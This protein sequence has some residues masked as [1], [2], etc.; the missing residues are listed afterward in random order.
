MTELGG[1]LAGGIVAG[2]IYGVFA[3]CLCMLFRV[4]LVLN[5]AIGEFAMIGALGTDGL[6][7]LHGLPVALAIP[8]VLLA[9]AAFS[10]LFDLTVLRPAV[11]RDHG[12]D[13][14]FILFF[15]TLAL[16]FFLQGV[17][18]NLFG[19]EVHGA[20]SIWPGDS[21][22]IAG[23]RVQRAGLLVL[24]LALAV[25]AAFAAYLRSSLAGKAM[26]ACG[27]NDIGARI[28]GIRPGTLRRATFVGMAVLAAVFGI[29]LSPL[30]GFTYASGATLGLSGLIAA[31]FAGLTSPARA[32]T[33]GVGIGIAEAMIAGYVTTEYQVALVY[34]LLIAVILARPQL[35]GTA[36]GATR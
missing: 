5:L 2:A 28:V 10:Y 1:F 8:A 12:N 34:G 3:V 13:V 7:R 20:P 9:I 15:F 26:T 33:A 4:S 17:G 25:G 18:R 21:V 29:V 6:V 36:A 22:A 27:E 16:A 11:A 19:I 24:A 35:L 23:V 30:S 32:I 31:G 14:I